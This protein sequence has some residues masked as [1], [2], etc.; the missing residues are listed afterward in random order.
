MRWLVAAVALVPVILVGAVAGFG[1]LPQARR[2]ILSHHQEMA[3]AVAFQVAEHLR[4]AERDM[5]ALANYLATRPGFAAADLAALLDAHAGPGDAFEAIYLT[6]DHDAIVA[7]GLSQGQ[8]QHRPDL[9]GL[10]L[11]Q[12]AFLRTARQAGEPSWS[13]PFLS[14]VSGNLAVAFAAPLPGRVL[15]GEITVDRITKFIRSMPAQSRLAIALLDGRG[16]VIACS[17]K[18]FAGQHLAP[19]QSRVIWAELLTGPESELFPLG[20]RQYLGIFLDVHRLGWKVVVAQPLGQALRPLKTTLWALGAGLVSALV[21]ALAAGWLLARGLA[22]DFQRYASLARAIAQGHYD[23]EPLA[24]PV[25]EFANLGS[26]LQKMAAAIRQR[27]RALAHSEAR[28]LKAQAVGHVGSFELDLTTGLVWGSAESFRIYQLPS[29]PDGTM[30]WAAVQE[31]PLPE[32]RPRLDQALE[33]LVTRGLPYDQEIRIRDLHSPEPR[34]VRSLAD[35]EYGPDGKP[36][37]VVGTVQDITPQKLAEL[38]LEANRRLLLETQALARLS[39]YVLDLTTG[40]WEGSSLLDEILGLAPDYPRNRASG[41]AL[42]HPDDR[43]EMTLLLEPTTLLA[44][45]RFDREVRVIR[46]QDQGEVWVRVLGRLE[47]DEAGRPAKLIGALQDI[48]PRKE[49]ERQFFQAQKMEVVGQLAGGVAH[50]FNNMLMVILG[51]TEL[52]QAQFPPESQEA[53]RLGQIQKA[54]QHS[55]D[56]TRQLLAFSRK[57]LISPSP[58]DLNQLVDATQKT[59]LSLIGENISLTFHPAPEIWPV[60]L[61]PAQVDQILVNLAVNARDAMPQGGKLLIETHNTVLDANY[62]RHHQEAL[63][64]EFVQLAVSDVGQGMDAATVAR[65]FEPFFT[66]KGPGQGTGLGLATVYGIVKQNGGFINVY[67][68][69]RRGTTFKVYLPRHLGGDGPRPSAAAVKPEIGSGTILLVEDDELVRQ[70]A[71][72]MLEELGYKVISPLSAREALHLCR[73][74]RQAFDLLLTDV[75]MPDLS[76]RELHRQIQALRPGLRAVFMSGYTSN[77]IAHHGVLEE[78]VHFLA[79]PFTITDIAA[80]MREALA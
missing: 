7:L 28:L 15:V 16:Q 73:K 51:Y 30:D 78:G 39:H 45:Q 13:Q 14:T 11:S 23:Q 60:K 31:V 79:K 68:E 34:Y 46:P 40:A 6:D 27:E 53:Q 4:G 56:I 1:L 21:L 8:N 67:S 37:R 36:R 75:I 3:H 52:L 55:R 62:C 64:G 58:Q 65:I 42:I 5:H 29:T 33:D 70:V 69:P 24:S 71:A 9:L 43:A 32:E 2:G 44:K 26:D 63:P 57:Q 72:S 50:D 12:R 54:A 48:T 18:A 49:L 66:T 38:E 41:L 22:G 20:G 77:I 25:Q 80:T 61:D 74:N 17:Q 59:L 10:D 35:L 19:Q 47:C 76:G